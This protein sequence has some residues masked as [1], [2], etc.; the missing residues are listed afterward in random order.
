MQAGKITGH[1]YIFN[2]RKEIDD[3]FVPAT[4]DYGDVD[5]G[6]IE[7]ALQWG[8]VNKELGTSGK[9]Y[10]RGGLFFDFVSNALDFFGDNQ[11]INVTK[12][13]LRSGKFVLFALR[14]FI[15][16][17][18]Y[19]RGVNSLSSGLLEDSYFLDQRKTQQMLG[20]VDDYQVDRFIDESMKRQA[21]TNNPDGVAKR[22]ICSQLWELATKSTVHKL[23][24]YPLVPF[25][26]MFKNGL[27]SI[28]FYSL[29]VWAALLWRFRFLRSFEMNS[30]DRLPKFVLYKV[31]SNFST[32]FKNKCEEIAGPARDT[33]INYLK[34]QFGEGYKTDGKSASDLYQE[35]FWTRVK[36][37]KDG[38]KEPKKELERKIS[39]GDCIKASSDLTARPS[40]GVV[41]P[42]SPLD[43]GYQR[44]HSFTD[45]VGPFVGL[46]GIGIVLFVEPIKC[47]M[48]VFNIERGKNLINAISSS[49]IMLSSVRYFTQLVRPLERESNV[50]DSRIKKESERGKPNEALMEL[51][52]V[53]DKMKAAATEGKIAG[54]ISALVPIGHLIRPWFPENKLFNF[55]FNCADTYNENS[56]PLLFSARRGA[57]GEG[58]LLD[59]KARQANVDIAKLSNTDLNSLSTEAEDRTKSF[60][61]DSNVLPMVKAADKYVSNWME[62]LIG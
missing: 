18:I 16:Y 61:G 5:A 2:S 48:S 6:G 39:R 10:I 22:G 13:I 62:A 25:L 31:L 29:D 9:N 12:T 58:V 60:M 8:A 7:H 26:N 42:N 51:C 19:G 14:D 47:L 44:D 43:Q 17:S 55:L 56:I 4:F 40:K 49:R 57:L 21:E 27:G 24:G 35:A 1:Y 50:L 34:S 53:R 46:A 28:L 45:L 15:K 23:W 20:I 11:F 59:A 52:R 32:G 3:G 30:P 54:M 36:E 33:S 37:H 38:C 41:D